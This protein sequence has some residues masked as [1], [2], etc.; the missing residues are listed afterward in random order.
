MARLHPV[1]VPA[2]Y[3]RLLRRRRLKPRPGAP[4]YLEE[5]LDGTLIVAYD[6]RLYTGSGRRPGPRLQRLLR[7]AAV[8]AAE[9]SRGGKL[10]YLELYGGPVAGSGEGWHSGEPLSVALVDAARAPAHVGPVAEAALLARHVEHAEKRSLAEAIG[11]RHPRSLVL[12][13]APKPWELPRLSAAWPGRE[14]AVL[15]LY[16]ADG[17]RL[18]PDMG[19]KTRGILEVKL[20]RTWYPGAWT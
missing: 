17:H 13:H 5:K 12:G 9:A 1:A 19:F 6:G 14:G 11:A 16:A 2:D 10:L 18:P 4:L 7:E 8:D 20:R 3:E 15:K